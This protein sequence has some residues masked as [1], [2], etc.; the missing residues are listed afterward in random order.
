MKSTI[1]N[2]LCVLFVL[3]TLT[4]SFSTYASAANDGW[5]YANS[6]PNGITSDK[7]TIQYKNVYKKTAKTSPGTGWTNKGYAYSQYE[8]SGEPYYSNIE[9]ATS[10]TRVMLSYSYYHW[11]GRDANGNAN[12]ENSGVYNHWDGI[13]PGNF[14]EAGV[15]TDS[16]DSRYKYYRLKYY[17]GTDVKCSS[18]F[19][20]DGSHGTHGG[21]SYFWYKTTRYQDRVKVDYYNFEKQSDWS[22]KIDS[23]ASYYTVRYKLNHTHS[24]GDWVT[25]QKATFD[26]DGSRYRTCTGC[27]VKQT[28]KIPKASSVKLSATS[29]TYDGKVKSPSVT[30]KNSSGTKLGSSYYSVTYAKGRKEVGTYKLAVKLKGKYYSGSKTFSFKII[31]PQVKTVKYKIGENAVTLQ[32]SKVAGSSI[33][34]RVCSYNSTTGKLTL[35]KTVSTTKITITNLKSSSKYSFVI[36]AAK[37]VGDTTYNSKSSSIVT[38]Q[39]YGKPSKVSGLTAS[40]K[41]STAIALKWNKASGNKVVYQVYSYNSSTK[42]YTKLAQVSSTSYTVKNLKANTTYKFAVRAY[43]TAGQGYAGTASDIYTVKTNKK[44]ST[45]SVG[46]I[47]LSTERKMNNVLIKWTASS[48]ATGYKI[49]RSTTGKS[50]SFTCIKTISSSSVSSYNDTQVSP[51][52]T[53]YYAVRSYKKSGSEVAYGAY[54]DVKKVTT[55]SAWNENLNLYHLTFSF[56]NY[57][58]DFGYPSNYRTPLNTY[59]IIFGNTVLA[60]Q[61]YNEYNKDG[62]YWGG[63]CQGMSTAAALLNVRTSGVKVSDF[64]SQAKR[65]ADLGVKDYNSSLGFNLTTFIEALQVSQISSYIKKNWGYNDVNKLINAVNEGSYTGKPTIVGVWSEDRAHALLG[66]WVYRPNNYELRIQVY[67]PNYPGS[68]NE[69]VIHTTSSG[70]YTGWSYLNE[71]GSSFSDAFIGSLEYDVYSYMWTNRGNFTSELAKT[72][73][74]ITNSDDISIYDENN[75][76]VAVMSDGIMV[77]GDTE[78]CV[79]DEVRSAD[80]E[81]ETMVLYLPEGQ[82]YTVINNDDDIAEFE[83]TMV[84]VDRSAEVS[85]E[86]DTVTFTVSDKEEVNTVSVDAEKGEEYTVVLEYSESLDR[87][88]VEVSGVGKGKTVDVDGEV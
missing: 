71:Y 9:L 55:Y 46:T 78:M 61:M 88:T 18:G 22:S 7:Y 1:K 3:F 52:V 38:I 75:K 12:F 42:K 15:F 60:Q 65:P 40:S 30:V 83:A 45:P 54:S 4:A 31:P 59:K 66:Y 80:D 58:G 53:Y 16:D 29:Y 8:N 10:E 68:D 57:A 87:E 64:N 86:A 6:L 79:V 21:R 24:Y 85:T 35:I 20:C 56:V 13:N 76:L 39:P 27:K 70:E 81:A 49:Y 5:T 73:T 69:V 77:E 48:S 74:L 19:S 25:T 33:K 63:N 23:T 37:K 47:T 32:W 17:D 28:S 72:N 41:S 62:E 82:T 14:Y 26:K 2:L 36:L 50:D 67:D 44:L 11:C 43:S 34:Y 51:A 84:N